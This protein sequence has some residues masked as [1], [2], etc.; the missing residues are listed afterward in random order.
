[1]GRKTGDL[2][3]GEATMELLT[4]FYVL[5]ARYIYS[6]HDTSG[7]VQGNAEP[8]VHH[9]RNQSHHPSTS[10]GMVDGVGMPSTQCLQ[11]C[12]VAEDNTPV[13][14]KVQ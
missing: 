10:Q 2:T 11:L 1:M 8:F 3:Q 5:N 14:A 4:T 13:S 7:A 12:V 9:S 6:L